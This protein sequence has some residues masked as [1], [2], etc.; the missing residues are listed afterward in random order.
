[1]F[2][3]N[4]ALIRVDKV[5]SSKFGRLAQVESKG[6]VEGETIGIHKA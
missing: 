4:L 3:S 1:M 6:N 2:N 5:T